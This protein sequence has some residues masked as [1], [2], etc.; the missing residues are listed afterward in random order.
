MKYKMD[1]DQVVKNFLPKIKMIALNLISGLPSSV[2]LDDLIQEGVI[3][4]LQAYGRYDAHNESGAQFYTYAMRRIKGA[5]FDYLRKI[6]WLPKEIR[7][8]LKNYETLISTSDEFLTDKEIKEKLKIT[9]KEL[10]KIKLFLR[11]SQILKLDYYFTEDS[12]EYMFDGTSEEYDPEVIAY[13][14]IL[15]DK[16]KEKIDN[17]KEKEKLLLSLYYEKGLTFKEIGKI[18]NVS[19]SRISQ[20]HSKLLIILRQQLKGD[21]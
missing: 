1:A 9:Q 12:D 13:K 10:N 21:E 4:L 19:E 17:L 6:D 18:M 8:L 5:M 2:E 20:I 3:G 7:H 15:K 14:S 11:K 16:L